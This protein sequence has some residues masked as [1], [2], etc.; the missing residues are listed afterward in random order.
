MT[1]EWYCNI[2]G[3]EIGPLSPQQLK[4]MAEKG[5]ILPDD[6]VRRGP[7]GEWVAAAQIEGLLPV[8]DSP[9][10]VVAP[11]MADAN[12]PRVEPQPPLAPP[13]ATPKE[14]VADPTSI[15]IVADPPRVEPDSL[16][17]RVKRQR[18]QQAKLIGVLLGSILLLGVV[19]LY[20]S[21]GGGEEKRGLSGLADRATRKDAEK[22]RPKK[23]QTPE[24]LE[25]QEGVIPLDKP[26]ENEPKDIAK[27]LGIKGEN[28]EEREKKE[29]EKPIEGKDDA[30]A[31]ETEAEPEKKKNPLLDRNWIDA[32]TAAAVVGFVAVRI[33]S[34]ELA[35]PLDG[36]ADSPPRILITVAV[37]NGGVRDVD[38]KGWSR[39]GAARDAKLYDDKGEP[40]AAQ[41]AGRAA[42]PG[43][44]P[45]T[46]IPNGGLCKELLA[47]SAPPRDAEYV[48]LEL[49]AA[50][51]GVKAVVRLK[52]PAAMIAEQQLDQPPPEKPDGPP[53]RTPQSDFGLPDVD[54]TIE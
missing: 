51:F 32:S 34:A 49:P 42:L 9:P 12:R 19:A 45:P 43:G 44:S 28:K 23:H 16:P 29:A 21:Y 22:P 10:P 31:A 33:A 14:A 30:P 37:Q 11:P 1:A 2:A 13:I 17:A 15:R 47:F 18:E 27:I 8:S 38:F 53:P 36:E 46:S 40:L 25:K 3:R 7:Q 6:R 48:L 35:P 54:E 52:I 5:Q 39:D 26:L 4:T 20:M 41:S 50:A 24:A